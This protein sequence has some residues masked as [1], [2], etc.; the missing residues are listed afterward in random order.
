M[1]INDAL[2]IF[3][4]DNG[5]PEDGGVSQRWAKM[6]LGPIIFPMPNNKGRKRALLYH[7]IHHV[8]TG[9]KGVMREEFLIGSWEVASGCKNYYSA[10]MYNLC[11]LALGLPLYPRRVYQAFIRGRHSRNFYGSGISGVNL[12]GRTVQSAKYDL[13][14]D[15]P[16]FSPT[17]KDNVA[18]IWW[19]F[20]AVIATLLPIVVLAAIVWTI[21]K[22]I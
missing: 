2:L 19:S 9:Y 1:T 14:L 15:E 8:L 4:K 7:D 18:F 17:G 6:K 22:V 21:V 11:A 3:R 12:L 20:I 13:N 16:Y 5:L 10:W